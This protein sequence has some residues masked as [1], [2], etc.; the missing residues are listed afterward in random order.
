[1]IYT[2]GYQY[3]NRSIGHSV[4][5]DSEQIAFGATLVNPDG[6]SWEFAAQDAKINRQGANPVHSVSLAPVT[7]RSADVYHRREL[8]RGDLKLGFGFERRDAVAPGT[9]SDDVR[10]F[11]EWA[12]TFN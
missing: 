10:G 12:R 1:V 2:D 11:V 7:I 9:G 4:D 6:S 8:L 5:G 3:R